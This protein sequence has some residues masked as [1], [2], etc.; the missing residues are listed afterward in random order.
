MGKLIQVSIPEEL[1]KKLD[2][3]QGSYTTRNALIISL[4]NKGLEK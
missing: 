1:E 3:Q 2:A 4:I